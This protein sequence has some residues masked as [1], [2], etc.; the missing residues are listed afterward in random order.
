MDLPSI[1]CEAESPSIEG[2][3]WVAALIFFELLRFSAFFVQVYDLID[4]R[5]S[6][7]SRARMAVWK[8]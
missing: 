8:A 4:K 2:W 7:H 6:N 5:R 1:E 3:A